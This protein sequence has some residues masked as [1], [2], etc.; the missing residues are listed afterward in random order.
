MQKVLILFLPVP[1]FWS[2]YDQQASR[3]IFQASRMDNE[4][5]GFMEIKPEHMLLLQAILVMIFIPVSNW[6]IYP[7]LRIVGIE[8][9]LQKMAVGGICL[10]LAFVFSGIIE[11]D[12]NRNETLK[13]SLNGTQLSVQNLMP[14]AY[15]VKTNLVD[16]QDFEVKPQ[17]T[18]EKNLNLENS[19]IIYEVHTEDS[20]CPGLKSGNITIYLQKW[21]EIVMIVM[22][23]ESDNSVLNVYQVH[24][25]PNHLMTA[26]TS[27]VV[28]SELKSRATHILW[29][30]PQ[31]ICMA[32]SEVLFA[33]PGLEFSFTQAPNSMK[34]V[35]MGFWYLTVTFGN[36][37]TIII[38]SAGIFTS[39]V[40]EYFV[41]AGL[42]LVDMI[43][44]IWLAYSYKP[45]TVKNLQD[46]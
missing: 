39:Q 29:Q 21:E 3:W 11:I 35:L 13:S 22:L 5:N 40:T 9:P 38:S 18:F 34:S 8:R 33:I 16:L 14:C 1:I 25:G 46:N 15:S 24:S 37:I 32:L 20:H 7:L 23:P 2:L 4:I 30:V 27:E 10:A 44:F 45:P 6:V 12:L 43:I 26:G 41:Y 42:M 17:E 31:H 28:E 36:I 19:T